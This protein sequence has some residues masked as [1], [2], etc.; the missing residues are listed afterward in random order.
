MRRFFGRG[1]ISMNSNEFGAALGAPD[2][3]PVRDLSP[4]FFC[5]SSNLVCAKVPAQC[6]WNVM[7]KQNAE[8]AP[9]ALPRKKGFLS[10]AGRLRMG[11]ARQ[12]RG[13]PASLPIAENAVV[14]SDAGSA[15]HGPAAL[16]ARLR[17]H[18]RAI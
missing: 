9:D 5:R 8:H 2:Q 10:P 17:F 12:S 16:H 4:A 14:D 1:A 15:H 7:V 6:Y 13:V 3:F 11:R 18:E